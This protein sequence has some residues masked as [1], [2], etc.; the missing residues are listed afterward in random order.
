MLNLSDILKLLDQL[1]IWKTL[2]AQP[3]RID[4]LEERIAKLE[5]ASQRPAR[6]P[7]QPCPECGAHALRRT[8]S[9]PSAGPFGALG[10]RDEVWTCAESGARDEREAVR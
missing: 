2:K 5:Q 7:G 8:E 9:K 6:A 4:A 1:P 3:A 10:A